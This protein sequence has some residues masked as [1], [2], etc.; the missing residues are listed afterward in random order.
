MNIVVNNLGFRSKAN[1]WDKPSKKESK[2]MSLDLN[3]SFASRKTNRATGIRR[4]IKQLNEHFQ[5]DENI[6]KK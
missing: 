5:A 3:F 4:M 6:T 1:C 2:D